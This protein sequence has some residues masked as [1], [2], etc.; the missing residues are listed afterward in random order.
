M[1]EV[2]EIIFVVN[3]SVF[4]SQYCYSPAF[5]DEEGEHIL[6][7]IVDIP[8]GVGYDDDMSLFTRDKFR[9]L[10]HYVF[11]LFLVRLTSERP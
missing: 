10:F 6:P 11:V 2:W 4:G 3:I 5:C 9:R 8:G 1:V 7:E